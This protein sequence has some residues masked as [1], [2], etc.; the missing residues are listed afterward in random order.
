MNSLLLLFLI[1]LFV[2]FSAVCSGLNVSLMNLNLED[3]KR[4][5]K[6]KNRKAKKIL[7]LR[8]NYHLSLAA[9]LITNVASVSATS[10]VLNT[11]V[12]GFLAGIIATLLIVIIGEIIPQALFINR[13]LDYTARFANLLKLMVIFTYPISKPLQLVLDRLFP[14]KKSGLQ[15]RKELGLLISEHLT[16]DTSELD[17]DEVFIIKGALQLSEKR[18]RDIMTPISKTYYLNLT[19][20]LNDKKLDEIKDQGYSRIPVFNRELTDCYGV[21]L[22]KELIDIDFDN[23]V[24]RVADMKIHPSP[25]VGSMTALD[26][27]FRKYIIGKSHLLPVEKDDKVVGVVSI[28]DLIE[29]IIGREIEDETDSKN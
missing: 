19:D 16:N 21:I 2:T 14:H 17:N 22:M 18:V 11:K 28:E 8:E 27:L 24:Y 29:E 6:L 10:L 1:A 26:T 4:K 5:A 23:N 20:V 15:T 9:L 7:P 13:S 3:L 12:N 25:L